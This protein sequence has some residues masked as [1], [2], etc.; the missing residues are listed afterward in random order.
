[1]Q[2]KEPATLEL[3]KTYPCPSCKQ[4]TLIPITL[5]EAWGCDRCK[6]IFERTETLH[7]VSKLSSPYPQQRLWQWDGH[8]L[9]AASQK[10]EQ[11]AP[12]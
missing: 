5:T 10:K 3:E 7:S 8:K 12:L 6:Q 1:M 2:S 4:G 11:A 9:D